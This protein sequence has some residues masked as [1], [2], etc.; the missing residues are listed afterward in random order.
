MWMRRCSAARSSAA[1][2][3]ERNARPSVIGSRTP[4]GKEGGRLVQDRWTRIALIAVVLLLAAFVA[5]PY[6]ARL[7]YAEDAPRTVTAR[8]DLSPAERSTVELFQR[9]SPSVVHVFAQ[10]RARPRSL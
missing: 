6:V 10:A 1:T 4:R 7:F 2:D 9:A 5:E 3:R 8:G